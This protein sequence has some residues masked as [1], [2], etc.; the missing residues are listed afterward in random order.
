MAAHL[1][2]DVAVIESDRRYQPTRTPCPVYAVGDD[3]LTATSSSRKPRECS[4]NQFGTWRWE[5]V[6][7]HGY[8]AAMGW[9]IWRQESES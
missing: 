1:G 8:A 2:E 4:N 9:R 6:E 7:T 5:E 3:Y